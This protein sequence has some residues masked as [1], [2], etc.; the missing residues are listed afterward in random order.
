[1][2]FNSVKALIL[3]SL[4]IIVLYTIGLFLPIITNSKSSEIKTFDKS[5]Q[6]LIV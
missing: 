1:M 2:K 5:N 6:I 4:I 3:V